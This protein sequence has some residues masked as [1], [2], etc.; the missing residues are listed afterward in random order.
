MPRFSS[1]LLSPCLLSPCFCYCS[2]FLA[3]Q[4]KRLLARRPKARQE[5]R[6]VEA[7]ETYIL[8]GRKETYILHKRPIFST[9][10]Q[11]REESRLLLFSPR[12]SCLAFSC[13]AL[14]TLQGKRSED[15]KRPIFCIRDLYF[16][17]ICKLRKAREAR[18]ERQGKEKRRRRGRARQGTTSTCPRPSR[19]E[20][21]KSFRSLFKWLIQKLRFALR[22]RVRQGKRSEDGEDG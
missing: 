19:D 21:Y 22:G 2:F 7:K 3:S 18:T 5:K 16:Q 8:R 4:G 20:T 15:G 6:G 13:P 14:Q 17:Q 10:L 1:S 11:T 9:N 12:F